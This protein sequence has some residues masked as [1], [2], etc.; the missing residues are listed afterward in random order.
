[1]TD[2]IANQPVIAQGSGKPMPGLAPMPPSAAPIVRIRNLYKSF[3]NARVLHNLSLDVAPREHLVIIGP[4]GSGKSTL[5]RL[6]MT[7]DRPD[8]GDIEIDGDAL[9]EMPCGNRR[10]PANA[11]H[12]RKVRGKIGMVFQSFNLFPHMRVLNNVTEAPIHVLKLPKEEARLRAVNLLDRV[13]LK[14]RLQAWP[15]QLSGGQRQRVA[16]A[17][18]LALQ[19]K[20]MLFDEITSALD[21]ETVGEVLDVVRELAAETDM[22]MLFVTHQM[23]FAREVADRVLFFDQGAIMEQGDPQTIFSNPSQPRTREFLKR[24]ID[25]T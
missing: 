23:R 24:V 17:R 4:S 1:M 13:G 7:L 8:S 20:I 14:D 22:T 12:L 25:A 18:A 11:A 10:V 5:L 9:W 3:S 15:A 6:L 2:I 21:P 16:I 19:P